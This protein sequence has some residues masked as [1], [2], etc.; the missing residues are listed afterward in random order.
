MLKFSK[1]CVALGAEVWMTVVDVIPKEDI[2][3][4][5]K[6]AMPA[7]LTSECARLKEENDFIN[8]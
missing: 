6:Y 2:K 7:V 5:G 8:K 1:E 4:H 3:N